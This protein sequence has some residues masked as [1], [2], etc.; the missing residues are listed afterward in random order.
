M[1]VPVHR[2]VYLYSYLPSL[3]L[4]VL[5]LAGLLDACWKETAQVWEQSALLLPVF[6][7]SLLGLG[8]LYGAITAG[9]TVAGYAAL[10]R[11]GKWPGKFVCAVFLVASVAVFLYF[12][13]IW[14]PLPL[15]TDDIE[16]RL[17]FT[18][19]GLPNWK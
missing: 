9:V 3:Y 17:W 7:V 10:V 1:F 5:A 2:S 11:L 13:P 6:A 15:T 19:A 14:I 18:N 8:Y 12:L 4:G 16:A